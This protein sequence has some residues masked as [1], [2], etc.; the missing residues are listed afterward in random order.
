MQ[1]HTLND[2]QTERFGGTRAYSEVSKWNSDTFHI[3]PHSWSPK[4]RRGK[5]QN[6]LY[7]YVVTPLLQT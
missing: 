5:K 1:L 2:M 3:E 4:N 7:L 6:L